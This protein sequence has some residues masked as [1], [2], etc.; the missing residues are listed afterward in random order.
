M[1]GGSTKLNKPICVRDLDDDNVIVQ[2][3]SGAMLRGNSCLPTTVAISNGEVFVIEVEER[4]N[5]QACKWLRVRSV[6]YGS[7]DSDDGHVV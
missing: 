4:V 7:N 5:V 1:V 2:C 3:M 6:V